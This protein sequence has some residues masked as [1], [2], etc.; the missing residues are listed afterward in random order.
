MQNLAGEFESAVIS[1]DQP[2]TTFNF[3][4]DYV[5]AKNKPFAIAE[6]NAV[7]HN[8]PLIR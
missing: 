6:T 8:S 1:T 2:N 7:F 4:R 5:T 3:Y